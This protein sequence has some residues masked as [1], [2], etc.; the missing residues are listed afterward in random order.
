MAS[1]DDEA[2][3]CGSGE[4]PGMRHHDIQHDGNGMSRRRS[5]PGPSTHTER[6]AQRSPHTRTRELMSDTEKEKEK[7]HAPK[8]APEPR[9]EGRRP[10]KE[11]ERQQQRAREDRQ[12]A[13]GTYTGE[14]AAI[15]REREVGERG[16]AQAGA[17]GRERRQP[18]VSRDEVRRPAR[19]QAPV[20]QRARAGDDRGRAGR[21]RKSRRLP[22]HGSVRRSRKDL[23]R[24]TRAACTRPAH[25]T[26]SGASRGRGRRRA[27]LEHSSVKTARR[28]AHSA[29]R[30]A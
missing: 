6:A 15:R 20:S 19:W 25:S 12:E 18:E 22:I 1:H 24:D 10:R 17:R 13:P 4:K 30:A 5:D 2:W 21:H 7:G 16:P 8:T 23:G 11:E 28:R 29:S 27:W 3:S 9:S 26:R 14:E